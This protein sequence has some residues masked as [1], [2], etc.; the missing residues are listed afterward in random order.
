MQIYNFDKNRKIIKEEVDFRINNNKSNLKKILEENKKNYNI[1]INNIEG[2]NKELFEFDEINKD[3]TVIS[4]KTFG[5]K[6]LSSPLIYTN[7]TNKIFSYDKFTNCDFNHIKFINCTFSG[8]IFEKCNFN[9]VSFLNCNLNSD[10]EV[11]SFFEKCTFENCEFEKSNLKNALFDE[12]YIENIKFV[13]TSLRN[14]IFNKCNMKNIV[15]ADCDLKSMKT[16]ETN[17]YNLNFEDEYLSKMDENTFIDKLKINKK[18][19]NIYENISKCY[20]NISAVFE[21]NRLFNYAGE[22]FYLSKCAEQKCLK[23]FSKI[24][25]YIFYYICGYGERPTFAL[26]TSLEIVFIFAILYMFLGLCV[27]ERVIHYDLNIILY[28]STKTIYLDMIDCF[29]FSLATFT[30]VGYGDIFPIGY[31]ILLSCIEMILGVTLVGVW[32]ATLARKITR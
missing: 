6:C 25:S 15:F 2:D 19:K 20:K 17:I 11:I 32:T 22:Y 23:G 9:N 3:F 26:I 29:Y 14:T 24:K 30:T 1:K 21:K 8:S 16:V 7:I 12:D 18:D 28:I 31:S 4:K 13:L 5:V 27:N 10:K